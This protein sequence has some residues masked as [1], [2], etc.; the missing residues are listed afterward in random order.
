[1][2]I[3]IPTMTRKQRY[4]QSCEKTKMLKTLFICYGMV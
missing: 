4:Y 1:M 3:P 2:W